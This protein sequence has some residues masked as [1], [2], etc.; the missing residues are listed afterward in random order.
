LHVHLHVVVPDGIFTRESG[1]RAIFH[2]APAPTPTELATVVARVATRMVRWLSR[3]GHLEERDQPDANDDS[4][5]GWL[6]LSLAG[7]IF[8]KLNADGEESEDRDEADS[9]FGHR[10]RGP[11]SAE[12][13]G[14]SLHAGVQMAAADRE[15][16]ERLFRYCARPSLSQERF[17]MLPDGRVA[18]ALKKPGRRGA[19]HRVMEPLELM[20]RLAALVP[21][22]WHPLTRF[23]GVLAPHHAWR[24][25]VV[26]EGV[27]EEPA[28]CRR[29]HRRAQLPLDLEDPSAPP[30]L[31]STKAREKQTNRIDWARLLARTFDID[32]LRCPGCGGRLEV[33]EVVTD[34]ARARWWLARRGLCDEPPRPPRRAAPPQQLRLPFGPPPWPSLRPR[35]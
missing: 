35:A 8:A 11:M 2:A 23:H 21:P 32:V 22:P 4:P 28:G 33:I 20:A 12:A 3:H 10:A 17:S 9:R 30:E 27:A 26:P 24:S 34:Q 31:Q 14:F 5:A 1:E 15:G 18:Y 29:P 25:S 13:Q 19:T 7:G 6:Q 16:R